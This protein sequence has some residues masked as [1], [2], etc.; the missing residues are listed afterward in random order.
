MNIIRR[1]GCNEANIDYAQTTLEMQC[2]SQ[3]GAS[4]V[5]WMQGPPSRPREYK[6]SA[7]EEHI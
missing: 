1:Q 5:S 3:D 7:E 6:T 4:W 2:M